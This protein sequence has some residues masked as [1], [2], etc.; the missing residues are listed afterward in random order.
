M[1]IRIH[2]LPEIN[3]SK[4]PKSYIAENPGDC[5]DLTDKRAF[6]L[7]CEFKDCVSVGCIVAEPVK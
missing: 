7:A 4:N 2:E 3:S 5:R 6:E 1:K